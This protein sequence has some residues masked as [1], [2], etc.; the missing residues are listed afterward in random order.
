MSSYVG[1]RR[2][3]GMWVGGEGVGA[4]W[5]GWA[6][7]VTASHFWRLSLGNLYH[8]VK[9]MFARESSRR[10]G[11]EAQG[12]GRERLRRADVERLLVV[13]LF[14]SRSFT[15]NAN[16]S[17]FDSCVMK[18]LHRSSSKKTTWP[19]EKGRDHVE[20]QQFYVYMIFVHQR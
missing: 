17:I 1:G 14:S 4:V 12:E 9:A 13:S 18:P 19:I 6:A 16:A 8:L 5:G 11:S 7:G 3:A 15:L 2:A 20:L 10:A